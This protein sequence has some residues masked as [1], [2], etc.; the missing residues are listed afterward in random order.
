MFRR[1]I[2]AALISALVVGCG[3]S[4]PS[5]SSPPAPVVGKARDAQFELVITASQNRYRV[6][7]P[8]QVATRLTYVGPKKQIKITHSGGG[9]VI[10]SLEQ[11]DGPFDP[12]GGSDASCGGSVLEA[13]MPVDAAYQKSGGWSGEDPMADRYKAFFA[14]PLV[15]LEPGAYRFTAHADFY[16]GGCGEGG[17]QHDI[18]ASVT[19][20][21]VP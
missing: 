19:V 13:G 21:V 5:A 17:A 6:N 15:R 9:A 7:Q 11:L 4:S 3:P 20:E 12:G 1:A 8:V 14:D 2:L 18:V 10:V 16:E